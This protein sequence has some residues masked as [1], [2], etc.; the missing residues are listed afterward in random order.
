[1]KFVADLELHGKFFP[2][3]ARCDRAAR[4]SLASEAGRRTHTDLPPIRLPKSYA[5]VK[6]PSSNA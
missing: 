3:E 1:M 6:V 2:A 5:S 4:H